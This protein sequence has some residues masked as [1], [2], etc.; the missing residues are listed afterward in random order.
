MEKWLR[1]TFCIHKHSMIVGF[2]IIARVDQHCQPPHD[3][4]RS[5][6]SK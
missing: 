2:R 1:H 5:P 4:N 3:Q 6:R